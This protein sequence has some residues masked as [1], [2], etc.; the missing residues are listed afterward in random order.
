MAASSAVSAVATSLL[1]S[2]LT[3]M[4]CELL[5]SILT[6][7]GAFQIVGSA[8]DRKTLLE[9][10]LAHAPEVALI[11]LA[12][13][14]GPT[15]GLAALKELH[16]R[17]PKTFAIVLM[18]KHNPDIV[19]EAF[20]LGARGVFLREQPLQLLL[21]CIRVVREGQIWASSADLIRILDVLS[22][23][24]SLSVNNAKG[25]ELLSKREREIVTLVAQGMTNR[26]V[27]AQAHLSENTVKNYL[28]RVF[29]KLGVSSRAELIIYAL[30]RLKLSE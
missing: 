20:R 27:A 11:S 26:E 14:D 7:N 30:N 13:E 12:L 2:D 24:N 23:S 28:L 16:A 25:E 1:I 15:S 5:T 29:D 4:G 10:A 9:A 8:R 19:V 17:A 22:T 21:R 3:Q 6:A 18:D